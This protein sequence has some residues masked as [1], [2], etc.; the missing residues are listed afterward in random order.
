MTRKKPVSLLLVEDDLADQ[1][2]FKRFV[3][4]EQLPY[5]YTI[6]GSVAEAV[7]LLKKQ[8]F[9]IVLADHA[10]GDGTAFDIVEYITMATPI[11]LVNGSG[12]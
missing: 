11:I 7:D 1:M 2:S 6:A 12:K 3:K 4:Q 10:L 8:T 9:D 5:D